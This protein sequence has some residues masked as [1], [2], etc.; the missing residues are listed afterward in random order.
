MLLVSSLTI[1]DGLQRSS[2]NG[3]QMLCGLDVVCG[4]NDKSSESIEPVTR[5]KN[6]VVY[7]FTRNIFSEFD[8]QKIGK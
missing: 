3:L 1:D 5:K 7:S 4:S 2:F 8:T 6:S